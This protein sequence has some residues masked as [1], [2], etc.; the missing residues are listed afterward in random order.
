[1]SFAAFCNQ[2]RAHRRFIRCSTAFGLLLAMQINGSALA[3]ATGAPKRGGVLHVAASTEPTTLDCMTTTATACHDFTQNFFEPLYAVDRAYRVVPMLADG[4]PA[5]S[6]G[7]KTA[8]I[9]LRR[10]VVFHD[11]SPLR[12][13]DV[14]ASIE[15]WG[16]L[17]G[18]GRVVFAFVESVRAVDPATVRIVLKRPFVPLLNDLANEQLIVIPARIAAA[19]GVKPLADTQLVGTGPYRF[20]S[21]QHG[22]GLKLKRFDRY[23]PRTDDVGGFGGRKIA[24]IDE[25]DFDIVKDQ[26]VRLSGLQSGQWAFVEGLSPDALPQVKSMSNVTA[27]IV[28]PANW[29]AIVP[30]KAGGTLAD[31][32]LRQAISLALDRAGIARGT[33]PEWSWYLDGSIFFPTQR[34]LYSLAGTEA[35]AK[36]DREHAKALLR[37]AGYAGQPILYMTTKDIMWM[38]NVAQVLV[39]Q[40][41]AIGLKVDLETYDWPT[42]LARRNARTGWDMFVTGFSRTVD[43]TANIWLNPNWP[44][45]Y[46]SPRMEDLLARWGTAQAPSVKSDL[47]RAIQE[48][49]YTELPVIKIANLRGLDAHASALKGYVPFADGGAFWNVW[50]EP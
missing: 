25:L 7:G 31:V 35:Y 11:G 2:L 42:L 40:L 27:D 44:G 17:T 28:D 16:K 24:Y 34:G 48:T 30:N 32:K 29:F 5:M 1:M 18:A 33:G 15:R 9:R 37:E 14:V 47:I 38:Y 41:E 22:Q 49:V 36:H 4:Y 43:P 50:L 6:N 12:A 20:D 23:A 39:P 46:V 13:E 8:S 21:W 45:F 19:A 10:G 26:Q 3:G